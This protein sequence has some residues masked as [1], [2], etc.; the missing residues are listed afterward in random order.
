MAI[1]PS[2]TNLGVILIKVNKVSPKIMHLKM[3]SAKCQP[4]HLGLNMLANL[5]SACLG[6]NEGGL[7]NVSLV[8]Q[9]N[10]LWDSTNSKAHKLRSWEHEMPLFIEIDSCRQ[11][12]GSFV[13]QLQMLWS[14]FYLSKF[15]CSGAEL[16]WKDMKICLFSIILWCW[17]WWQ[18]AWLQ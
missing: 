2:I 1:G 11:D 13:K 3:L 5:L 17:Y 8:W 4:H 7:N 9:Y 15:K 16:E 12:M 6:C 14:I 10:R 18:S